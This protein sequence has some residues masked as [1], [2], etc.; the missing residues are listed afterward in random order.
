MFTASL[1]SDRH[2][3]PEVKS[4]RFLTLEECKSLHGHSLVIDRNGKIANVAITSIK[5]WKTRQDVQIGWKFGLYEFGKDT[6]TCDDD[7][8]F[9]VTEVTE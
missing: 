9:F 6:F 4:Y 8:N 1:R 5:T 7:N 2:V 3:N